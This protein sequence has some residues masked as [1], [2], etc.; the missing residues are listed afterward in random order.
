VQKAPFGWSITGAAAVLRRHGPRECIMIV[1]EVLSGVS[2]D[3]IWSSDAAGRDPAT[4]T[5]MDVRRREPR[6]SLGE[7]SQRIMLVVFIGVLMFALNY[8]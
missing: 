7:R 2:S 5:R 3:C 6:W 4:R 8:R 1:L